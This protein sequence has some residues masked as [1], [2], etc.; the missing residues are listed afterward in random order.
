LKA[1]GD[2]LI[3]S[4]TS[5]RSSNP[6][7][8]REKSQSVQ[9]LPLCSTHTEKHPSFCLYPP[10]TQQQLTAAQTMTTKRAREGTQKMPPPKAPKK[11]HTTAATTK[12][13][14]PDAAGV[15]LGHWS[16]DDEDDEEEGE[17]SPETLT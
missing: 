6:N 14:L 15:E 9:Y 3:A 17:V 5:K 2:D 8:T 11:A 12:T 4:E 1:C 10:S 13:K 7:P 16:D